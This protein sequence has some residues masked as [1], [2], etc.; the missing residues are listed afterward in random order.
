M[1]KTI[2]LNQRELILFYQYGQDANC[3][4]ERDAE[5]SCQTSSILIIGGQFVSPRLCYSQARYFTRAQETFPR[6]HG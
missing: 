3:A 5:L 4:C 6:F 2:S 1:Q